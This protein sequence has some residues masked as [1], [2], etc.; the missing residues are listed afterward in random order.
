MRDR[1]STRVGV[2]ESAFPFGPTF[3]HDG[4]WVAYST[5]LEAIGP[6]S[7]VTNA[8]F[9]EPFP[10][11]GA[12]Y[13]VSKDDDGHHPVW[14]PGDRELIYTRGPGQVAVVGMTL[15]PAFSFTDPA[16]I[17]AGMIS[18]SPAQR[19]NH[20]VL[21]DGRRFVAVV[22]AA[23]SRSNAALAQG[24]IALNWFEEVKRLAPIE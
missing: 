10:A 4:R 2:A 17:G 16:T 24:E 11:T 21:P 20:D 23:A 13:Q 7:I 1:T 3:S 12:K 15:M 18:I 6:F 22:E 9:V 19:R 8:V 5:Q 14:V